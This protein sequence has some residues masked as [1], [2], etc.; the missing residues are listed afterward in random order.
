M[1]IKKSIIF[2]IAILVVVVLVVGWTLFPSVDG[3]IKDW[4]SV[5][6]NISGQWKT[7]LWITFEDGTEVLA[8]DLGGDSIFTLFRE[9]DNEQPIK[10]L[11]YT[12]SAKAEGDYPQAF[13][14]LE[15]VDVRFQLW[16]GTEQ[17]E[18]AGF[19]EGNYGS[20][21]IQVDGTWQE[22][23]SSTL[24]ITGPEIEGAI[25]EHPYDIYHFMFSIDGI[26]KYRG[27]ADDAFEEIDSPVTA[28]IFLIPIELELFIDLSGD[29]TV[30]YE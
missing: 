25:S 13:I 17:I 21:T 16:A 1:V 10:H 30:I 11:K 14:H 15:D 8:D 22:L 4:N 6:P 5:D 27:D 29:V 7:E 24:D 23:F 20:V 12:V 28:S 9:A 26:I 2:G 18:E 19:T 3:A